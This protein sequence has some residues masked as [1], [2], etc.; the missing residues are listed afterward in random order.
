MKSYLYLAGDSCSVKPT[1]I[2]ESYSRLKVTSPGFTESQPCSQNHA[3]IWA[4]T[5]IPY[6]LVLPGSCSKEWLV[7]PKKNH[8]REGFEGNS[9]GKYR[10]WFGR[11]IS[12]LLTLCPYLVIP[13]GVGVCLHNCKQK[14]WPTVPG[15]HH[16]WIVSLK[17]EAEIINLEK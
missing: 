15:K 11:I 17:H 6:F 2:A 9:S 3:F 1:F 13:K 14:P 10:W 4:D 5:V 8:I 12:I 7:W 16:L